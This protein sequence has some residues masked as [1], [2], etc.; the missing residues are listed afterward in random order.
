MKKRRT[1]TRNSAEVA[2]RLGIEWN[3]GTGASVRNVHVTCFDQDLFIVE[4]L[5]P[6]GKIKHFNQTYANFDEIF[7]E[8]IFWRISLGEFLV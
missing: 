4:I 6:V 3:R 2:N 8:N 7:L 5:I 1:G